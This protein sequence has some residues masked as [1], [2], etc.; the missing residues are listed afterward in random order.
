MI[1]PS[2]LRDGCETVIDRLAL[3]LAHAGAQDHNVI[4]ARRKLVFEAVEMLISLR[5]INGERPLR[6][7]STTSSQ[8]RRVRVWSSTNSWYRV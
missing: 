7:E 8:I 4:D 5:Q 2:C 6:T 3:L 1:R